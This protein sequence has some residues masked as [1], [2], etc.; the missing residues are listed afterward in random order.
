M[1]NKNK[2]IDFD[3][4]RFLLYR[5]CISR[6]FLWN[7]VGCCF[8][9]KLH[10]DGYI[11]SFAYSPAVF[12]C[13]FFSPSV[14]NPIRAAKELGV[15][16]CLQQSSLTSGTRW[17]CLELSCFTRRSVCELHAH[18]FVT[19]VLCRFAWIPVKKQTNKQRYSRKCNAYIILGV[20]THFP[21]STTS[22]FHL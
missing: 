13:F 19:L 20:F 14:F 10:Y 4:I 1:W 11:S 5:V 22:K 9:C 17:M 21:V 6:Y 2:N 16:P 7:I 18:I 8:Y 12:F 15:Q 3:I